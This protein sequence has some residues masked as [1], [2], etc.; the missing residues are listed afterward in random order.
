MRAVCSRS[1]S[2]HS[3][4]RSAC[5]NA[6]WPYSDDP[7]AATT[8][9]AAAASTATAAVAKARSVSAARYVIRDV[10]TPALRQDR[11]DDCTEERLLPYHG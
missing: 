7:S 6:L 3:L 4:A 8:S 5:E 2:D 9:L 10:R 1:R 11:Y